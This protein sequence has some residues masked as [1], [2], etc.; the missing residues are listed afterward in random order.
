MFVV[1]QGAYMCSQ[2]GSQNA[3]PLWCRRLGPHLSVYVGAK[4]VVFQAACEC[5][6]STLCV[7]AEVTKQQ[8]P[9]LETL[10]V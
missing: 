10:H 3:V 7:L 8:A 6:F 4:S 1:E 5:L 2:F 9:G